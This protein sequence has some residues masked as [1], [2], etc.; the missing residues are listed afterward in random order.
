MIFKRKY[1]GGL[2]IAPIREAI[3]AARQADDPDAMGQAVAQARR[4]GFV[5]LADDALAQM[6]TM[7]G[8]VRCEECGKPGWDGFRDCASCKE[9]WRAEKRTSSYGSTRRKVPRVQQAAHRR[10]A[11]CDRIRLSGG[12]RNG[13]RNP[14]RYVKRTKKRRRGEKWWMQPFGVYVLQRSWEHLRGQLPDMN[15][16]EKWTEAEI[17]LHGTLVRAEL[18]RR[19]GAMAA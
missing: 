7:T 14:W 8:T 19:K 2:R 15:R 9:R 13:D 5:Q 12:W 6:D 10:L 18:A 4:N 11:A 16:R 1:R 3:V 17:D